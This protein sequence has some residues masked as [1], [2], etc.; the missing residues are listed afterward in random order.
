MHVYVSEL[1]TIG[2]DNGLLPGQHQAIIWTNAMM[3]LIGSLETNFSEILN[4]IHIFSFKKIH[5][6]M[7]SVKWWP[8]CL[9]P[10]ALTYWGL[11]MHIYASDEVI[12]AACLATSFFWIQCWF[13]VN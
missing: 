7:L 4:E 1:T 2:S 9:S 11:M 5:L 12:V 6:Q 3:L 10:N 8:F 13:I